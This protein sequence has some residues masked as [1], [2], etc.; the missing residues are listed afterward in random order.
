MTH[1][2]SVVFAVPAGTEVTTHPLPSFTTLVTIDRYG[3]RITGT[4]SAIGLLL[5]SGCEESNEG[6]A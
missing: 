5:A 4:E 3:I 6:G 1:R 2:D